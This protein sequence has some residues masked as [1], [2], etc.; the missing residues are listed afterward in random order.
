MPT[1]LQKLLNIRRE[2]VA[3]TLASAAFF[4]C[5]LTALMVLRPA[6]EALGMQRGLDAVRWLFLGTAVVTLAVNPVFGLLVSRMRRLA[7]ITATYGFFA[8]SLLVFYGLLTMAPQS[9]GDVSGMVFYVWFSVFNFFST[10]VF[11]PSWPTASPWSRASA[12]SASWQS[13]ERS[14]PCS[15]RGWPRSWRSHL[16]RRAC[17]W[18]R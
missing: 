4:F 13:E 18:W 1:F 8:G 11:W 12:S 6:R 10:M 2:E 9:V 16:A 17:C 3:P 14:A 5:V 15:V 7:F